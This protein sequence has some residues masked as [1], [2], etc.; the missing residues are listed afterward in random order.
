MNASKT[1]MVSIIFRPSWMA[2]ITPTRFT[3]LLLLLGLGMPRMDSA[4][5]SSHFRA[6]RTWTSYSSTGCSCLDALFVLAAFET[7]R[8]RAPAAIAAVSTM[9][10]VLAIRNLGAQSARNLTP[11]QSTDAPSAI[12]TLPALTLLS[13][14]LIAAVRTRCGTLPAAFGTGALRLARLGGSAGADVR[15]LLASL[16]FLDLVCFLLHFLPSPHG[17]FLLSLLCPTH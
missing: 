16:R 14:A 5:F 3:G 8:V 6:R 4:Q 1:K 13:A 7:L 10:L 17:L 15:P 11:Q 12:R 2:L 9:Q